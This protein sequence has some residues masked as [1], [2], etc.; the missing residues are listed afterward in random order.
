[1]R[2]AA[3]TEQLAQ[4][5]LRRAAP[6]EQLAQSNLRRA[7]WAEQ[8]ARSGLGRATCAEQPARRNSRLATRVKQL[9]RSAEPSETRAFP[10]RGRSAAGRR[11]EACETRRSPGRAK[12]R[13]AYARHGA[14]R[15]AETAGREGGR[16]APGAPFPGAEPTVRG[17]S[18]KPRTSLLSLLSPA[19]AMARPCEKEAAPA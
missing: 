1:M 4:S 18:L 7:T 2:R 17:A 13:A 8:L 6:A 5:N 19:Q 10:A 9:A 3:R 14:R 11:S 15:R 16:A 12:K